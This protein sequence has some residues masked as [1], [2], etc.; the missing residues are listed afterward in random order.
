M[1][2]PTLEELETAADEILSKAK[3][4]EELD[5][6]EISE[7]AEAED[8][9][10][11]DEPDDDA[12]DADDTDDEG[13]EEDSEDED[14]DDVKKSL[15][16]AI[17]DSDDDPAAET[18]NAVA[19][20]IAKSMADVMDNVTGSREYSENSNAILAKSLLAQNVILHE[21]AESLQKTNRRLSSMTKSLEEKLD[22]LEAKI[23]KL[24]AQPAHMRKSVASY[25]ERNFA[26]SVG[27]TGAGSQ[28]LSKAQVNEILTNELM[29]G[30]GIVTAQDIV[31]LESGAAMRPEI[32]ALIDSRRAR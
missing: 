30:S 23:D 13:E 21:Q 1:Q 12:D 22:L 6:D 11:D 9:V 29:S 2:Q 17:L 5:P 16:S 24:G 14:D 26:E 32:T 8:E 25:T 27:G 7:D 10:I 19:E 18:M 20:I 3:K 28:Q 4:S 15:Q 31:A